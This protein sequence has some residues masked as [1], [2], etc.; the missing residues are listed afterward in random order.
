M[1]QLKCPNCGGNVDRQRM[2]C[3]YCGTQF[4]R[5]HDD[6][7]IRIETYNPKMEV[8]EASVIVPGWDA[9]ALGTK[10]TAE[11]MTRELANRIAESI[12]PL[13][14]IKTSYD[15][16]RH[17]YMARAKVRILEPDYRF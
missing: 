13:M 17:E 14:E 15:A 2:I 6:N 10:T 9:Q 1:E 3:P 7:L 12:A 11:Y 16:R 8:I 4:K 5:E